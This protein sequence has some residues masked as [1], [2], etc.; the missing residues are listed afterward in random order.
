MFRFLSLLVVCTVV[1]CISRTPP[2]VQAEPPPED[3]RPVVWA[4]STAG[5][6]PCV[7]AKKALDAPDVPFRVVWDPEGI[8]SPSEKYPNFAWSTEK[9][10]HK[11]MKQNWTTEGWFNKGHFISGFVLSRLK[12]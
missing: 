6:V 10:P 8:P 9:V 12:E 11:N 5:C 2:T 3:P 7:A 1:G 4:W